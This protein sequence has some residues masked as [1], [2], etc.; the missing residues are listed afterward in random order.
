MAWNIFVERDRA[1]IQKKE[2]G[3]NEQDWEP[4]NLDLKILAIGTA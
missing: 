1:H 3:V 2:M 4:S